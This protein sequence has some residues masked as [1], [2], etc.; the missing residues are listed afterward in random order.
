M[1]TDWWNGLADA[2]TATLTLADLDRC[3]ELAKER[4]QAEA[5]R[6]AAQERQRYYAMRSRPSPFGRFV[7]L[8]EA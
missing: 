8:T 4:D 1:N 6:R 3:S 5:E 2:S 7:D